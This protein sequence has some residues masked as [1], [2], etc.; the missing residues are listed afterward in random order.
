[1]SNL[2]IPN[3]DRLISHLE[4]LPEEKFNMQALYS[5]N[6]HSEFIENNRGRVAHT[7][8]TAA[9]IAGWILEIDRSLEWQCSS[10]GTWLQIDRVA[11]IKLFTPP[12]YYQPERYPLSRAI[13]TLKHMRS[14]YLRTG[15]VV[16]DWDA[17]EPE[18]KPAWTAP[19]AVEQTKPALPAEIVRFLRPA[20]LEVV[21]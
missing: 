15:S 8:G 9:C 11:A 1:M 10:A 17:P 4:G 6:G 21:S 16:V 7:C 2:N 5:E 14:E 20:D 12:S 3:L 13:R 18:A 19:K